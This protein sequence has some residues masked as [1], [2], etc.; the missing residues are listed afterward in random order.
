M[1]WLEEARKQQP[2]RMYNGEKKWLYYCQLGDERHGVYLDSVG[3]DQ[4]IYM[5]ATVP[6]GKSQDHAALPIAYLNA[7]RNGWIENPGAG[8]AYAGWLNRNWGTC[9]FHIENHRVYMARLI[10]KLFNEQP[11]ET[12]ALFPSDWP[13]SAWFTVES[14]QIEIL[15]NSDNENGP[16]PHECEIHIYEDGNTQRPPLK[17]SAEHHIKSWYPKDMEYIKSKGEKMLGF[18]L[19]VYSLEDAFDDSD[20][21]PYQIAWAKLHL[22]PTVEIV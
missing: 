12:Y 4:A 5:V 9:L 3:A 2:E 10:D 14:H 19:E 21:E 6:P 1:Y 16:E 7:E 13:E 11:N 18:L 15:Q 20:L 22:S 8:A 17:Y